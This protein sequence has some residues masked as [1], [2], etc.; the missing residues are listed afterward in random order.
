MFHSSAAYPDMSAVTGGS[1]SNATGYHQTHQTP[2]SGAPVYVPS[3]RAIS[4]YTGAHFTGAVAAQNGW[5]GDGF[6]A[7]HTPLPHQFYAQNAVMMSSWR[8]YDPSGFQRTS[9]YGS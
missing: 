2:V 6:S 8:A 3:N 9:P 5:P 7:A 4:Q 1:G